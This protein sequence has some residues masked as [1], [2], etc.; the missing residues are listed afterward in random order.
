MLRVLFILSLWLVG[1]ACAGQKDDT[2]MYP[3]LS[4]IG[5]ALQVR[6]GAVYVTKLVPAA[7]AAKSGSIHEGDQLLAVEVGGAFAPLAGKTLREVV[8]LL[9]GPVGTKINVRVL[10][11]GGSKFIEVLLTR[12]PLRLFG[13]QDISYARLVGSQIPA[14][15]MGDLAAPHRP[16]RLKD[17]RGKVVVLDFWATWCP[18]CY[19]PVAKLQTLR[20][21]NSG[22]EERVELM[23]VAVD[24]D[25]ASA[26]R[27]VRT[28][29]W[30]RTRHVSA[31]SE[32]LSKIGVS[33]LP[34]VIIVGPAGNI[35]AMAGAHSIDV[36]EA[37]NALL[38]EGKKN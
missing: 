31:D 6:D 16:V 30:N 13:G 8:P 22:W 35:R 1:G 34:V 7:A 29:E 18:A 33:V 25:P 12:Q 11:K 38:A 28:Q 26:L 24:K 19:A 3:V 9:R 10:S 15:A 36:A 5:V 23:A 2:T 27:V 4:G 17:F 14:I 20:D 21:S 32:A 37:V